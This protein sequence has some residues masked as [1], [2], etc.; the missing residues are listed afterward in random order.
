ML[1]LLWVS[2]CHLVNVI[3]SC[4]D[5]TCRLLWQVYQSIFREK[6]FDKLVDITQNTGFPV[7]ALLN[8]GLTAQ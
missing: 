8:S 7:P 3:F 1:L 4:P 5:Y 6:R 2:K